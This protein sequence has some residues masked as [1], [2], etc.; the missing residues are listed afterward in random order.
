[1]EE[2]TAGRAISLE[3]IDRASVRHLAESDNAHQQTAASVG[4]NVHHI[5]L[6]RQDEIQAF[7]STLSGSDSKKFLQ[8]YQEEMQALAQAS[9]DAAAA[10]HAQISFD[11]IANSAKQVQTMNSSSKIGNWISIAISIVAILS[12]IKLFL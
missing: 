4:K 6:D 2:S 8:L 12:I 5:R 11:Q 10:M 3:T 1:M 7:A 9:I